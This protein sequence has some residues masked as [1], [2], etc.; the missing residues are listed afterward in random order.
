ML[1]FYLANLMN[2]FSPKRLCFT[3]C[4]YYIEQGFPTICSGTLLYQKWKWVTIVVGYWSYSFSNFYVSPE[5]KS[6]GKHETDNGGTLLVS[7]M[8]LQFWRDIDLIPL[9]I[10]V[11]P[12]LKSVGKDWTIITSFVLFFSF[13]NRHILLESLSTSLIPVFFS[14]SWF[15]KKMFIMLHHSKW[16]V[17]DY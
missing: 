13:F 8:V 5:I 7:Q 4:V 3:T 1:I 12:E 9:T 6:A 11:Y 10:S 14:C 2:T 15:E 16:Y 17:V